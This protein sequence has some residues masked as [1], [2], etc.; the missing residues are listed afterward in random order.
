[1]F[2]LKNQNPSEI[3][4]LINIRNYMKIQSENC[5]VPRS[6]ASKYI[7][8]IDLIDLKI[9]ENIIELFEKYEDKK[10]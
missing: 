8:Y 4:D 7:K 1:M 5:N 2:R 10:Q 6:I 9:S 3:S